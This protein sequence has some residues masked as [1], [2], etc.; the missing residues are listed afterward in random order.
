[1]YIARSKRKK[2]MK[3]MFLILIL[4][5]L[6]I[7]IFVG[8]ILYL[9]RNNLSENSDSKYTYIKAENREC[10]NSV[11]NA[12]N[13]FDYYFNK[14]PTFDY[15]TQKGNIM[16]ENPS[17]NKF[18]MKIEVINKNGDLMYYTEK[19]PTGYYIDKIALSNTFEKGNYEAIMTVSVLDNDENVIKNVN[20]NL[21]II[22][23]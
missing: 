23:K 21:N 8:I 1:M 22:I 13:Q 16:V 10:D 7:F 4:S 19:L 14:T 20:E 11:Y 5:I 15:E 9:G 17:Y 18:S 2:H 3:N 6:L 12:D